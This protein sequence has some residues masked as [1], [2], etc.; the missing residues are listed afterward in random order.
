LNNFNGKLFIIIIYDEYVSHIQNIAFINLKRFG[1]KYIR[2]ISRKNACSIKLYPEIFDDLQ[3]YK[4]SWSKYK[5]G[6]RICCV[7]YKNHF[8]QRIALDAK[9]KITKWKHELCIT[10]TYSR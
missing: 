8:A 7:G 3:T 5:I 10:T 9:C 2:E 4:I 6:I 1:K